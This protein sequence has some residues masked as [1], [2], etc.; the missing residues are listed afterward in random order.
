[1]L[2]SA[3]EPNAD[4]TSY[5]FTLRDDAKFADGTAVTATTVD[6][7]F[8]FIETSKSA[9]FLYKMAGIKD[10]SVVDD[11]TV[12]IDLTAPNHLFL[13]ILPMYSFSIINMD[14][15]RKNGGAAWL[16]TNTA[17]TGP[18]A[19]TK[20]DPATE[21]V[22]TRKDAYWGDMPTL[23]EINVKV[24]GASNRV[25]LVSKGEVDLATEVP[26]KDVAS[27][28]QTEG[29]VIDSP[30]SNKILF[31]AMNNAV[32]PFDNVKVRQAVSYAIPYDK[33]AHRRHEGPGLGDAVRGGQDSTPGYTDAGFVYT[34]DLDK[35]KALLAE[36]GY[37]DGF[38]FDFTLGS[39]FT[40]DWATTPSSS[41]PNSPRSA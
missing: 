12:K 10:V 23:K 22:L 37:A 41:R 1:M 13:Q 21:S 29:V 17:G 36:A 33:A 6:K 32:A 5:T 34:H 39:G 11:K 25:Q 27:L 15:V 14:E 9:S 18:Y 30:P 4:N 38:T 2:A 7:T 35:A 16:D 8:A 19:V 40:D 31:F 20:W 28:E 24:M 26:P 3:W